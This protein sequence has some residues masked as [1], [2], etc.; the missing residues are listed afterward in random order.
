MAVP[1]LATTGCCAIARTERELL[2]LYRLIVVTQNPT[3]G[4]KTQI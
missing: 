1:K 3:A 2:D 4:K